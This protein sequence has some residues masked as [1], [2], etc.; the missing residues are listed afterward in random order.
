VRIFGYIV[1]KLKCNYN[2]FPKRHLL[3][4][5]HGRKLQNN[6]TGE[7]VSGRRANDMS[8][9]DWLPFPFICSLSISCSFQLYS[10]NEH[11]VQEYDI[12]NEDE[13]M[14]IVCDVLFTCPQY[15]NTGTMESFDTTSDI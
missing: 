14:N 9:I 5:I 3:E 12:L 1:L 13:I 11:V 7:A 4:R 6:Q 15:T 8:D 10:N 2:Y